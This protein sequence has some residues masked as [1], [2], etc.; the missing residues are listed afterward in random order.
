MN[1]IEIGAEVFFFLSFLMIFPF[2]VLEKPAFGGIKKKGRF[3]DFKGSFVLQGILFLVGFLFSLIGFV[4]VMVSCIHGSRLNES[5]S[6]L[7]IMMVFGILIGIVLGIFY[8]L[9]V[10]KPYFLRNFLQEF[11]QYERDLKSS[12][13]V[14]RASYLQWIFVGPFI[15]SFFGLGSAVGILLSCFL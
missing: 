7:G 1:G 8:W 9:K 2:F 6:L 5:F 15:C 13:G 12:P 4:L 10:R 11:S 14:L 3:D